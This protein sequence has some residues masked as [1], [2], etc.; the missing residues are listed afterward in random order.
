M[1]E[2]PIVNEIRKTRDNH[3]KKFNYD[4]TKIYKD[5]RKSQRKH[6]HKLVSLNPKRYLAPTGS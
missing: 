6:N 3:A 4:L 5:I 1:I 2:D